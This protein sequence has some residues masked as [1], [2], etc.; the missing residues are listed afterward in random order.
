M[1]GPPS[2]VGEY[3]GIEAWAITKNKTFSFKQHYMKGQRP[4]S[5]VNNCKKR[6]MKWLWGA[7]CHCQRQV[8]RFSLIQSMWRRFRITHTQISANHIFSCQSTC[9]AQK[10]RTINKT[11]WAQRVGLTIQLKKDEIVCLNMIYLAQIFVVSFSN[12]YCSQLDSKCLKLNSVQD[13]AK[14]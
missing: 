2:S 12:I 10:K 9:V 14:I 3:S 13:T 7:R 6:P 4:V 8:L 5:P 1:D 11:V